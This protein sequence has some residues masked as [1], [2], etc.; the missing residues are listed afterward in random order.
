LEW[1]P[2]PH[3]W[4]QAIL[5]P[6]YGVGH[7]LGALLHALIASRYPITSAGNVLMSFNNK[8][9]TGGEAAAGHEVV[10]AIA[11]CSLL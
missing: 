1:T 7:S 3:F 2:Q 9:A 4:L 10:R 5:L 6:R 8:P 11:S